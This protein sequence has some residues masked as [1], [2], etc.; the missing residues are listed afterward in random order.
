[1]MVDGTND[2]IDCDVILEQLQQYIDSEITSEADI[3]QIAQH[4]HECAPC[5]TEHD[6]LAHLRAMVKRSCAEQAPPTLRTR[7]I[8]QISYLHIETD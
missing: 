1:M 2:H 4:L 7:I 6:L 3:D 8:T 5:L